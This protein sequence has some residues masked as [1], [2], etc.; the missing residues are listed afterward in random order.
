MGQADYLRVGDWNIRCDRCGKKLKGSEA[1][2]TW[3]GYWVCPEHWEPRQPQDFVRSI[4]EYPTPA[5]VRNPADT[6]LSFGDALVLETNDT[7]IPYTIPDPSLEF[8]LLE[9]GTWI[10]S[11]T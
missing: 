8:I 1:K 2:Q 11:E 9:A 6:F 10:L 3:Q 5:F 7:T 4:Q